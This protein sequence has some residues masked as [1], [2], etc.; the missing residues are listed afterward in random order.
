MADISLVTKNILE[1]AT[2]TVNVGAD[3]GYPAARL[4]DRAVS[5]FWKKTGTAAIEIHIDQG[6][7]SILPVDFLAIHRHNLN[8]EDITWEY[9][10]NDAD[11]SPAVAAWTQGDNL[12][13]IK[14]LAAAATHRYWRVTITS[15]TDPMIGEVWMGTRLVVTVLANPSPAGGQVPNRQRNRTIGGV[16]RTTNFGPAVWQFS[17]AAALSAAQLTAWQAAMDDLDDYCLPFYVTD[18]QGSTYSALFDPDPAL[19]FSNPTHTWVPFG[20]KEIG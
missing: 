17:Y 8:G 9:S 20:I 18:H 11:W 6:A 15:M 7:A 12:Q 10:D 2:V 3:T 16:T 19:D 14:T 4:Y 5:F 13:I 1:D